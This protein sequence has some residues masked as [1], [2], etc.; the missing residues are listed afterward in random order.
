MKMHDGFFKVT[1][2]EVDAYAACQSLLDRR[3]CRA[4]LLLPGVI[5]KIGVPFSA[6]QFECFTFE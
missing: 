2:S 4:V 5:H 6:F 3:S 1:E